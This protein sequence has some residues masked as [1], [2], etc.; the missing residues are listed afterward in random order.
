M[1]NVFLE[2]VTRI[3]KHLHAGLFHL[4]SFEQ[5]SGGE[6]CSTHS[7]SSSRHQTK[8]LSGCFALQLRHGVGRPID[9]RPWVFIF[10]ST[11]DCPLLVTSIRS[12]FSSFSSSWSHARRRCTVA[13]SHVEHTALLKTTMQMQTGAPRNHRSLDASKSARFN[14]R[15]TN[16]CNRCV[17]T[18]RILSKAPQEV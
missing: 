1:L 5:R 6:S 4:P 8:R 18:R 7:S 15:S 10:W 17:K 12:A 3:L 9:D 2:T 13:H 14:L 11:S 16:Q